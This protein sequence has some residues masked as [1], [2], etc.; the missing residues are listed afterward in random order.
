MGA[1]LIIPALLAATAAA[2][3]VEYKFDVTRDRGTIYNPWTLSDDKVELRAF[4]GTGIKAGDF[5]APTI[6]VAPG[7]RLAAF[8]PGAMSAAADQLVAG[9]AVAWPWGLPLP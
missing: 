8:V 1:Y 9:T 5:V 6:R 3:T 2:P 7:Q 4:R